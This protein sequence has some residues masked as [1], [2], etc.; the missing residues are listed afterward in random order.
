MNM[1]NDIVSS[2]HLIV[3]NWP[4]VVMNHV[5]NMDKNPDNYAHGY[6]QEKNVNEGY[7]Y[8][9]DVVVSKV[10]SSQHISNS[11]VQYNTTSNPLYHHLNTF[12]KDIT[13]YVK[14]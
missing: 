2:L 3:Y 12:V 13:M 14:D 8:F 1:F 5:L 10:I 9:D 6:L 4:R 11:M 7:K